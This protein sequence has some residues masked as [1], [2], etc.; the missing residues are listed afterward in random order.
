MI[1]IKYYLVLN[2]NIFKSRLKIYYKYAKQKI[3]LKT[4]CQKLIFSDYFHECSCIKYKWLY[5]TFFVLKWNNDKHLSG[6]R[7]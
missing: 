7:I 2:A 6:Y 3:E 1:F 5:L 4:V